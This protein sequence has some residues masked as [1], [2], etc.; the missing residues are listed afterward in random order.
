MASTPPT[1]QYLLLPTLLLCVCFC[2]LVHAGAKDYKPFNNEVADESRLLHNAKEKSFSKFGEVEHPPFD[3]HWENIIHRNVHWPC[4]HAMDVMQSFS[5]LRLQ[6]YERKLYGT[7]R[8]RYHTRPGTRAGSDNGTAPTL[9]LWTYPNGSRFTGV[10][11]S[12]AKKRG[13]HHSRSGHHGKYHKG[14]GSPYYSQS[15][16]SSS[17]SSDE[18]GKSSWRHYYDDIRNDGSPSYEETTQRPP[19]EDDNSSSIDNGEDDDNATTALP[20]VVGSTVSV[21]NSTAPQGTVSTVSLI[22]RQRRSADEDLETCL[23][24]T[25]DLHV[26]NVHASAGAATL[27]VAGERF[28]LAYAT[29]ANPTVQLKATDTYTVIH[30]SGE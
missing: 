10:L 6:D 9:W 26:V 22:S 2:E 11:P 17:S 28:D 4:Q 19:A 29:S 23:S 16:S 30:N 18:N 7:P 25:M 3:P 21:V 5:V 20:Q 12:P 24:T 1:L 14:R 15:S 8:K 13:P 27:L